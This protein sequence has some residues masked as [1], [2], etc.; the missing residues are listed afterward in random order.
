MNTELPQIYNMILQ[1]LES[2][3]SQVQRNNTADPHS[4]N[5]TICCIGCLHSQVNIFIS[6]AHFAYNTFNYI[7][8]GESS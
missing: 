7:I 6:L 8:T 3:N 1:Y 4:K 2:Q 5:K